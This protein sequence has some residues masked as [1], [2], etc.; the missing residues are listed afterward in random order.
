MVMFYYNYFEDAENF[1]PRDV[2]P[3]PRHQ[4]DGEDEEEDTAAD[5]RTCFHFWEIKQC[6]VGC[7]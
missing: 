2:K 6:I 3:V 4:W 5:V 7:A 1:E